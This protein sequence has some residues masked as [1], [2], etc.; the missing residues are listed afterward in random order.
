MIKIPMKLVSISL[1]LFVSYSLQYLACL[2]SST[3]NDKL[4]FDV[5]LQEQSEGLLPT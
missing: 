2:S 1:V 4:A 3:S 5:G